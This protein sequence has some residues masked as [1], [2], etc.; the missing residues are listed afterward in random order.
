MKW[1]KEL[2]RAIGTLSPNCREAVR[3]QSEAMDH[4]LTFTQR[5][6]LR[7]H[8]LLCKWCR[9]YGNQIRFLRAASR[10]V[11]EKPSDPA[12]AGM[13]PEA[14]DRIRQSLDRERK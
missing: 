2:I 5:V 4:S 8:L 3:L 10:Q 12:S 9:R 14:R 11:P 13:S 6:G 1:L 7:I